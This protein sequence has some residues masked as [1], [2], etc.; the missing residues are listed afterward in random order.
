MQSWGSC[1]TC[2]WRACKT[3]RMFNPDPSPCNPSP[4]KYM[5]SSH[6]TN[7]VAWTSI[8]GLSISETF[9]ANHNNGIL[10]AIE[11]APWIVSFNV[12]VK[13]L[14]YM[15]F[16]HDL[17]TCVKKNIYNSPFCLVIFV[18]HSDNT[19]YNNPC[20]YCSYVIAFI[21]NSITSV[22]FTVLFQLPNA[23]NI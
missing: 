17:I 23:D 5:H 22:K 15:F 18:M 11:K 8:L 7:N 3:S 2:L 4:P 1:L 21:S 16:T 12:I 13:A 19:W 20:H 10:M 14:V 6:S 9:N